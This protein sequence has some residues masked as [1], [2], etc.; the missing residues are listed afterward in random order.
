MVAHLPL[1]LVDDRVWGSV[2]GEH[3]DRLLREPGW[4]G[5]C[6]SQRYQHRQQ[7]RF[8]DEQ[9]DLRLLEHGGGVPRAH[10]G[11]GLFPITKV[12]RADTVEQFLGRA[13]DQH[14]PILAQALAR[15]LP[16]RRSVLLA[17]KGRNIW[18]TMIG[19]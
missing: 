11:G 15:R 6:G 17:I 16:G 12:G 18:L 1:L 8:V 13:H 14:P 7:G 10:Q 3:R 9:C 19:S 4:Q 5:R 2:R